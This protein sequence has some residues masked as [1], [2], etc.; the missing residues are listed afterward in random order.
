MDDAE[1][2]AERLACT[3]CIGDDALR[4][5]AGD[6]GF[7]AECDYCGRV[8]TCVD[9]AWLADRVHPAF[10]DTFVP[11]DDD[12][13]T[14]PE[15]DQASGPV[16][17]AGAIARLAGL[18]VGLA[19]DVYG[20]LADL[21]LDADG[22]P[23]YPPQ[24]TYA[25]RTGRGPDAR[26]GHAPAALPEHGHAGH[27]SRDHLGEPATD[28]ATFRGRAP[29]ALHRW[30]AFVAASARARPGADDD[31]LDAL[32][33][34]FDGLDHLA[35]PKG[36]R[37][38]REFAAGKRAFAASV[39]AGV[40]TR[41][42]AVAGAA[43]DAQQRDPLY[44]A[45]AG[46]LNA[47]G[48]PALHLALRERTA[49]TESLAPRGAR[50]L[51]ARVRLARSVRVLDLEAARKS[52]ARTAA[53]GAGASGAQLRAEFLD[54][55]AAALRAAAA[56]A[57][58]DASRRATQRVGDWLAHAVS[59]RLDGLL[60]RAAH[61]PGRTLILFAPVATTGAVVGTRVRRYAVGELRA[62]Y[63]RVTPAGL[64]PRG[65]RTPPARD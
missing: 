59:P 17:G 11:V 26:A 54:G 8:G 63:R 52:L 41:V 56:R 51:V 47:A 39:E 46:P 12:A 32:K 42:D 9:V 60:V 34:A 36:R 31:V 15:I 30:T 48:T 18:D 10:Q 49:V 23:T 45:A 38:L 64:R 33:W 16:D 55:V 61:G 43:A 2:A 65:P 1:L 14:A 22:Q 58:D 24:R 3:R 37:A 44:A 50:V 27:S 29:P 40:D 7:E 35:T 19:R 4:R 21:F 57:T 25:I 28:L 13:T 53:A 20:T 6:A 62:R 5:E